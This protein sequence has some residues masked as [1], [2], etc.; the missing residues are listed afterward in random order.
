M[1]SREDVFFFQ[2]FGQAKAKICTFLSNNQ[3][4]NKVCL[5]YLFGMCLLLALCKC[6]MV[7][8][9]TGITAMPLS[10]PCVSHARDCSE[11]LGM[12]VGLTCSFRFHS[13]VS[14]WICG[15]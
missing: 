14:Y 5:N 12:A 4:A 3:N 8:R 7:G 13:R 10:C 15:P 2:E 9:V 11:S 1:F 6:L